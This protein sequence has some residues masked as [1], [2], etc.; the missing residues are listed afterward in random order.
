MK[1]FFHSKYPI[2]FLLAV[3]TFISYRINAQEELMQE[4]E[5]T[6]TKERDYTLA[7]FKGTRVVNGHSVETKGAGELEFIITHRFGR[8]NSGAVNFW[9]LDEAY[10]RIGLEYGITSRLG[11]GIG[12]NS[13]NDI[14]DGY[15]KYKVAK[16]TSGGFPFTVTAFASTGIQ[17]YPTKKDDST[18]NFF[19]RATYTYQLLIARK[20]SSKMSL[21]ISPVL[22]HSNRVDQTLM[23]N[24][25]YALGIGGRYKL[26][27]ST[28]I[29]TE[30]YYRINPHGD[31][32]YNN[33][34]AIGLDIETGGHVFQLIFSNT[35][36]MIERTFINESAGDFFKGDINFGFNITRTFQPRHKQK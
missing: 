3:F 25:Q 28:A 36:G 29:N 23:K 32:P 11:V 13:F 30:Y 27:P 20:F 1:P 26:T 19:D 24:D 6:K 10:I 2:L 31:T 34:L 15:L 8:L 7:T 5:Q 9:G 22:V 14:Y 12:R 18:L 21:Q 33:S 17:T 35:Q 16:Q 4:L